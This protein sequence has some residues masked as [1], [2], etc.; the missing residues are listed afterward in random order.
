MWALGRQRVFTVSR[1]T[2]ITF[3]C[4]PVKAMQYLPIALDFSGRFRPTTRLFFRV[5]SYFPSF[6][7]A[8]PSLIWQVLLIRVHVCV[9]SR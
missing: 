8:N 7:I 2:G 3:A 4:T 5:A 9:R 1:E 6:T